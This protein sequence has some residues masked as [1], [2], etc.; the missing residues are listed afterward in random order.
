[1]KN[2]LYLTIFGLNSDISEQLKS[3]IQNAFPQGTLLEWTTLAHPELDFIFIN[4]AFFHSQIIQNIISTHKHIKYLRLVNSPEKSGNINN[5]ILYYPFLKSYDLVSWLLNKEKNHQSILNHEATLSFD[6]IFTERN[7]FIRLY[8]HI[9]NI[10]IIDTRTERVFVDP[11]RNHI[12]FNH[13]IKQ[14]Y[15]K[16]SLVNELLK[17][18]ILFDLKIWLW[19]VL[20]QST[21]LLE[22]SNIQDSQCYILNEWPQINSLSNRRKLLKISA[23]FSKGAEVEYVVQNSEYTLTQVK[24][25]I[26]MTQ[27]LRMSESIPSAQAKFKIETAQFQ[28]NSSG[29][30]SSF[31]G[32]LRRKLGI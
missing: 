15:A 21:E 3:A 8:D 30:F 17:S 12:S 20:Y 23:F 14:S 11:K 25:F 26:L 6:E 31:L 7:G 5:D 10:A 4:D 22:L 32:K 2:T 27:L 18:F 29:I 13:E 9:G 16:S 28:Q 1:M 24:Q 19:Q